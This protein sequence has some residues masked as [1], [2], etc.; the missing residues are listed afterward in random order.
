MSISQVLCQVP[1]LGTPGRF[2]KKNLP[3]GH[4]G[5]DKLLASP[6]R[7]EARSALRPRSGARQVGGGNAWTVSSP[8]HYRMRDHPPPGLPP[9]GGG[10]TFPHGVGGRRAGVERR[11]E[12]FPE[13]T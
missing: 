11:G 1:L 12:P 10:P 7:G 2:L 8:T 4:D 13:I 3:V 5:V 9:L 6:Q